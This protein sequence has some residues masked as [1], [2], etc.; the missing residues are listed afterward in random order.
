MT[1]TGHS[2]MTEKGRQF[3][4]CHYR[5]QPEQVGWF[6]SLADGKDLG[7]CCYNDS[8]QV[9]KAVQEA[10]HSIREYDAKYNAFYDARENPLFARI[11]ELVYPEIRRDGKEGFTKV[12]QEGVGRDAPRGTSP[13]R[14]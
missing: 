7:I 6:L 14:G 3:I 13:R 10:F 9:D 2:I 1:N 4:H 8:N 11:C 12:V 5:T